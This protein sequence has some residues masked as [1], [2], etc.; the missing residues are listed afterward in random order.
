VGQS[1]SFTAVT[2][3][4]TII[5]YFV[6]AA[7]AGSITTLFMPSPYAATIASAGVGGAEQVEVNIPGYGQM[8]VTDN[9]NGNQTVDIPGMGKVEMTQDGE[10]VKVEGEGFNATVQNSPAA[11]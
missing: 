3:V 6:V 5:V 10:M 11:E 7:V 4:A 9:G 2:I 1:A 8:K